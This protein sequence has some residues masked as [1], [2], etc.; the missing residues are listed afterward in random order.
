MAQATPSISRHTP[1]TLAQHMTMATMTR[2][3]QLARGAVKEALKRQAVRLA[4]V[5]AKDISS[6]ARVY[7]DDHPA[8]IDQAR[9]EVQSWFARG[10]FGKRAAKAWANCAKLESVAQAA[11][12]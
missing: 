3:M 8:L 10:V 2:A 9:S 6:W 11:K 5:D 1:L 12:A 7:L 4:D